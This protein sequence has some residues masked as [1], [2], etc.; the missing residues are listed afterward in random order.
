MPVFRLSPVEDQKSNRS[1]AVST[2]CGK[3]HASAETEMMARMYAAKAFSVAAQTR[4]GEN[5]L[6]PPWTN[7]ELVECT[8]VAHVGAE[9][10]KGMVL[11]PADSGRLDFMAEGPNIG[12]VSKR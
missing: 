3:C 7:L 11:L 1:W 6:T 2:Y 9:P 5:T 12:E 4:P 10:P 8:K